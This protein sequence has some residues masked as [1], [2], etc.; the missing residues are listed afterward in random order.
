MKRMILASV[1]AL[2]TLGSVPAQG[3][4]S[5]YSGSILAEDA[6]VEFKIVKKKN[7]SKKI[8]GIAVKNVEAECEGEG[9][10]V[11]L[12]LEPAGSYKVKNNK[13]KVQDTE[14]FVYTFRFEGSLKKGG[15]AMGTTEFFGEVGGFGEPDDGRYC[16]VSERLWTA[17]K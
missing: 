1:L 9:D 16:E 17:K 5:T 15:K 12:I 11:P 8:K 6:T 13:F 10:P 2:A 14:P 7:G 4:R 3:G